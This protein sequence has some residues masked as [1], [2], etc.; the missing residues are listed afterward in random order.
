MRPGRGSKFGRNCWRPALIL[1]L[2]LQPAFGQRAVIN[3]YC[4]GCHSQRLKTAGVILEGLDPAN[5][6]DNPE[7]WERVLRQ[8]SAGQ[9]PPPGLPRPDVSTNKA[10]AKNLED[11]LDRSA[12]AKANPG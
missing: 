1:S 6:G 9:M 10:F 2:L 4:A 11:A 12:A 5:P 3:Q 8:V 7:L